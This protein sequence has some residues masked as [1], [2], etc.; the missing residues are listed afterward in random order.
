MRW[1]HET[2]DPKVSI[3]FLNIIFQLEFTFNVILLLVLGLN[4]TF[5]F[6]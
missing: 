3:V 4:I 5:L 2:S 1:Y 6:I